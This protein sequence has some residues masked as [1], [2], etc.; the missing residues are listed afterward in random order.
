MLDIQSISA[1]V[2]ALG[3]IVGVVFTILEPRNLA[4]KRDKW[5]CLSDLPTSTNDED[6][7]K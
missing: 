2:I 1:V 3:V 7:H 6:I 4:K 5:I